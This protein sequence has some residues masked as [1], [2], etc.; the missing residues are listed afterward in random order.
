MTNQIL[1]DLFYGRILPN[2]M[3]FRRESDYAK[4]L[5]EAVSYGNQIR[6]LLPDDQKDLVTKMEGAH[7]QCMC[8]AEVEQFSLGFRLGAQ[9][10]LAALTGKSE[11]FIEI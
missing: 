10:M 3:A 8:E 6:E 7:N 9:I 2:E 4:A 11:T 1:Q 5:A